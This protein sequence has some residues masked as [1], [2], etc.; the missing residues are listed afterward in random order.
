MTN[1]LVLAR[2]ILGR[3]QWKE[4]CTIKCSELDALAPE[5]RPDGRDGADDNPMI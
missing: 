3:T 1:E 4:T 2:T 5:C